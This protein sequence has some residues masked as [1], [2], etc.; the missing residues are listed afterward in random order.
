MVGRAEW[1]EGPTDNLLTH[2]DV[3]TCDNQLKRDTKG[4]SDGTDEAMMYIIV[5][6][7]LQVVSCSV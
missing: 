1:P 5:L 6:C 3:P 2:K 7:F 4:V